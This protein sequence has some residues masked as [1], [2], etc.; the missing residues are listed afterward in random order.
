MT[1][2]ISEENIGS[3]ITT[4]TALSKESYSVFSGWKNSG[5]HENFPI[6]KAK[7]RTAWIA[8]ARVSIKPDTRG[9]NVGWMCIPLCLILVVSKILPPVLLKFGPH[10]RQKRNEKQQKMELK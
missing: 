4:F 5:N 7:L 6:Y 3:T 8:V 10:W 9:V 2:P 1:R